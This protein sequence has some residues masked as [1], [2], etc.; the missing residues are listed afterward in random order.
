[1][2]GKHSL[3]LV[4]SAKD[5]EKGISGVSTSFSLS[6]KWF[7]IILTTCVACPNARC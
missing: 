3:A 4:C 2:H 1:M 6:N 7:Q 5:S